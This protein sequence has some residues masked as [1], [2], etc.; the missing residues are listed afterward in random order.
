MK[1]KVLGLLFFSLILSLK[2]IHFFWKNDNYHESRIELHK[3]RDTNDIIDINN[4]NTH[5]NNFKN[6]K[7]KNIK[8]EEDSCA[9]IHK[10][11]LKDEINYNPNFDDVKG[12]FESFN[13][14]SNRAQ[15]IIDSI[16]K[17]LENFYPFLD[18]AKEPPQGGFTFD[19]TDIIRELDS[20]L[21]NPYESDFKFMDDIA[22]TLMKLKDGHL[23]FISNCYNQIFTFDQQLTLYSAVKRGIQTIKIL[24][25]D[26]DPSLNDCEVVLIDGQPAMSV[27]TNFAN[28]QTFIARD[29][30]VR[31][32]SILGSIGLDNG[33]FRISQFTQQFT[34]SRRLP[35]KSYNSYLLKCG[36]EMK[37]IKRYWKINS[38]FYENFKDSTSYWNNFCAATTSIRIP[39]VFNDFNSEKTFDNSLSTGN[40]IHDATFARFYLSN[41]I[42]I[43]VLS[44]FVVGNS[45]PTIIMNNL[46]T[47]FEKLASNGAKK[48]VLDL[49][50]NIGGS[51]SIAEF[52]NILLFPITNPSFPS[53]TKITDFS[54]LAI[55]TATTKNLTDSIFYASQYKSFSTSE[56][57][58]NEIFTNSSSFIGNNEHERGHTK[59]RYT[60]Q[61]SYVQNSILF[62]EVFNSRKNANNKLP[63]TAKDMIIL[64][65]GICGSACTMISQHLSELNGVLTVAIGGYANAPLSFSSF[66]GGQSYNNLQLLYSLKQVGLIS[67]ERSPKPFE[68]D[69]FLNFP[70]FEIYSFRNNLQVLEFSYRAADQRLFYDEKSIRDPSLLWIQAAALISI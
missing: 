36:I 19:S 6:K 48:L 17:T 5:N 41:D 18:Q 51:I 68:V 67:D 31:F 22:S 40:L 24:N 7:F 16:K 65:N 29:L 12:C 38:S 21:L 57:G 56:D 50:N 70:I 25:D 11:Y 39:D 33:K 13:Y 63:W 43:A 28:S 66:P 53:D 34:K 14:D 42:G 59:S 45:D 47:G 20:L 27:L 60:N 35:S 52:I 44:T 61:F 46:M 9:I 15:R 8:K 26:A 23:F 64:T 1:S 58:G 3:K 30:G 10:N 4:N 55:N 54:K 32:N 62:Q 37:I 2:L 69:A 49:S